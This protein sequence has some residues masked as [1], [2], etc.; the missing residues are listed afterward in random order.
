M[1]NLSNT[2]QMVMLNIRGPSG[3]DQRYKLAEGSTLIVGQGQNCGLR[4]TGPQVSSIHCVLRLQGG[5]LS[6]Q[7]WCSQT[8]T[9][10]GEEQVTEELE[11]Q[12]G[13]VVRVG[14]FQITHNFCHDY[15]ESGRSERRQEV[16]QPQPTGDEDDER[17]LEEPM[18][19]AANVAVEE[20]FEL[21]DVEEESESV[22]SNSDE[23]AEEIVSTRS[24]CWQTDDAAPSRADAGASAPPRPFPLS[25]DEEAIALMQEEIELLQ[26]ELAERDARI[27]ELDALVESGTPVTPVPDASELDG[28]MGRLDDLLSELGQGDQRIRSLEEMLRASQEAN[29]AEQEEREQVEKWLNDIESRL[30]ERQAEWTAERDV[31]TRRIEEQRVQRDELYRQLE[32]ATAA[33]SSEVPRGALQKLQN[34][35]DA[36]QEQLRQAEEEQRRAE[37][38][39]KALE[40]QLSEGSYREQVEAAVREERLKLAQERAALSRERVELTQRSGEQTVSDSGNRLREADARFQAFRQ[41]L[42]EL[43]QQESAPTVQKTGLGSRLAELWRRLDG[44]TDTD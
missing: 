25:T 7:D 11:V 28:L 8:G 4:L 31:L 29:Q 22:T 33:V 32:Q 39:V 23:E 43:H 38:R 5:Q 10:L 20:T 37:E 1:S 9:F 26:A 35:L 21:D 40:G 18:S 6:V 12:P 3:S 30:A 24:E 34:E 13:M 16:P 36:M 2:E 27:R 44:P 41:T 42:R 14:E 19:D 15:L 17:D